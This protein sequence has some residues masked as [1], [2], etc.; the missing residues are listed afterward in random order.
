MCLVD[1]K[2]LLGSLVKLLKKWR[3]T[4]PT[5]DKSCSQPTGEMKGKHG[6]YLNLSKNTRNNANTMDKSLIS[7]VHLNPPK[8]GKS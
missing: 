8:F 3:Q 1:T 2:D 7:P 4:C 5:G 6:F